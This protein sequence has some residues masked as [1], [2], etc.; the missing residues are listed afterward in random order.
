MTLI[1]RGS[2]G[3]LQGDDAQTAG[4]TDVAT[5]KIRNAQLIVAVLRASNYTCLETTWSQQLPDWTD[6]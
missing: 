5:G 4:V 1:P 3:R 2:Q 6:R